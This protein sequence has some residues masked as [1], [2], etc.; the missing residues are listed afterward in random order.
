MKNDPLSPAP[1][2]GA[3]LALYRLDTLHETRLKLVKV[4]RVTPSGKV[5]LLGSKSRFDPSGKEIGAKG[6]SLLHLRWP[7]KLDL[8]DDR[9]QA[10]ILALNQRKWSQDPLD[11]LEA[12][13]AVL[14]LEVG[15][16]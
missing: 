3:T 2:P 13:A 7:T 10:L 9:R 6:I 5:V 1:T 15:A 14:G 16:P 8:D 12:V 11:K 4:H